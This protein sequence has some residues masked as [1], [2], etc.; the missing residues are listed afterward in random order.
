MVTS[1]IVCTVGI[2]LPFSP[3]AHALGFTPLPSLYWLILV[4][5]LVSYLVLTHIMKIWF[6]RRFG[7]D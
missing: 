6:H 3:F 2:W 4:G 5:M 7:L 1:L